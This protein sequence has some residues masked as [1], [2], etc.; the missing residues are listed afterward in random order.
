MNIPAPTTETVVNHELLRSIILRLFEIGALKFGKFSLKSGIE[1][2]VYVDLRLTVSYPSLLRDIAEVLL[3]VARDVPY[4]VMCGVPYTALPFATAMSI[5]TGIPMIM[6]RKE[7]KAHGTKQIIEGAWKEGQKCLIVEDL[8][9]SGMS[10]METVAPLKQINLQVTDVVVLLDRQQNARQNLQNNG[11][12][13]RAVFT[14]TQLLDTLVGEGRVQ[15]EVRLSVLKFVAKN[16]VILPSTNPSA[17]VVTD[18]NDVQIEM[19]PSG[20]TKPKQSCTLSYGK[21][22]QHMENNVGR[23]LLTLMEKKKTNL[24]VAADVTTTE[25]LIN[26]ANAVGP[27]ICLL[28]THADIISDWTLATARALQDAAITHD[29]LLFEDRKFADIGS[30]AFRQVSSGVHR[31]AD[32]A[33]IVNAHS[34]PGPGVISGLA[35]VADQGKDLG[36]LL[37]AEM[38]SEGNL[39][40]ALPAY[41]EMTLEMAQR[42][43]KSVF[44]FISMGKIAGDDF[45]YMTPGVSMSASGDALGQQYTSPEV[46]IG[47]KGSDV[48][49]VGRGIYKAADQAL[50]AQQYRD[51]GWKAYEMRCE[52]S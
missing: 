49:I 24:A 15:P 46:V 51:A 10:I 3:Y 19:P 45:V 42:H 22:A 43:K 18:K 35:K 11:L 32:W 50:A 5:Q 7:A 1:S 37:L 21:R 16:Q 52:R 14:M 30:T 29:F 36:L 41:K 12:N 34:V 6:R 47:Q 23:S 17:D 9:T 33:H 48:I 27:H 13:L 4:D 38:S 20:V 25:E 40:T 26:L 2:P 39:A 31:I 28:K 44:G 8:V